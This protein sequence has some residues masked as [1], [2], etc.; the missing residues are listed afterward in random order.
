VLTSGGLNAFGARAISLCVSMLFTFGLNRTLTFQAKGPIRLSE[1][2]AYIAASGMGMALNYLIYAGSLALGL[3]WLPA[4]V[5]GTLCAA[6]F[7]FFAYAR[8]FKRG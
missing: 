6:L 4:M 7:N 5:V 2:V 3:H 1:F 8:I